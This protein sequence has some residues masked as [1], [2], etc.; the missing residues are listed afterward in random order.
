MLRAHTVEEVRAAEAV[1]MATLPEGALMQRAA[2]GLAYAVVDLLGGAYGRRVV[3]LVGSGDNGGD[4]LYA[5]A[6][7]ARRGA[8]VEAWLLSATVHE[9]GLAALRGAGGRVGTPRPGTAFDVVV[10]GIV[11]IGG[12]PGLRDDARDALEV[13]G[14]VPV[15]AVDTP[16]GVDVDSGAAPDDHVV[17][18]LTV[19]FGTHKACHLLDPA[20]LACGA[21]ELVDIGL[22]PHLPPASVEALQPEDVA[23]MLPVPDPEDHKYTRGV[24][25]V[26]AGSAAYPGAGLLSVAG[27]ACGLAGMVRY[28]GDES[29]L[30]LV[31]AAHPEVV[32]PGRVQAWVV[33]SGSDTGAEQ[34]LRD[35]L[36]DDVP[37]VVDADAL[38]FADL[39]RGT[40]AVLT[41]H[42]GELS[43]MLGVDRDAIEAEPLAHARS[44][45]R[46]YD[47][48]VLLKGRHTV[49]A[50]PDGRVRVTTTGTQWLATA[51][52]GDVLGGVIG[53]LLATG[54][55]PFDAASAGSWLHGAAATLAAQDGPIVASDVAVALPDLIAGMGR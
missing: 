4:A 29:V 32:G 36:A 28:D 25:G 5:G 13:L 54:L 30:A 44:A 23:A 26:R 11:G 40:D 15:V 45:A 17:A 41:P 24:V 35:A 39:A 31:R 33:G 49:V 3:L 38:A 37:V 19:T 22:D 42:A 48:V 12:R 51:G 27:A 2:S 8:L 53:A 55:D 6:M 20:S 46:E 1:L 47:A 14:G 34:A 7:L 52:A 18:D 50:R 16:S 9:A 10:D 43:R 21:V